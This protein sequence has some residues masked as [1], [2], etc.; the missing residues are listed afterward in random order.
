MS[1]ITHKIQAKPQE[2]GLYGMPLTIL[3]YKIT[4]PNWEQEFLISASIMT[5]TEIHPD[6]KYGIEVWSKNIILIYNY[7]EK[8]RS[9]ILLD[10]AY[11]NEGVFYYAN[12]QNQ[13]EVIELTQIKR[14]HKIESILE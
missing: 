3:S 1:I 4:Y 11:F 14:I 9:S 10:Y 13:S 6:N 5:L 2:N 8:K 12:K 7:S